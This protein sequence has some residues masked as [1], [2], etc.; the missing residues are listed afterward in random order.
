ML[1]LYAFQTDHSYCQHSSGNYARLDSVFAAVKDAGTYRLHIEY[2]CNIPINSAQ[3]ESEN[4]V[5]DVVPDRMQSAGSPYT[6]EAQSKQGEDDRD[7]DT[8]YLKRHMYRS[9]RIHLFEYGID[10]TQNSMHLMPVIV[11]RGIDRIQFGH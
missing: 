9:V 8:D 5:E 4:A 2:R 6:L 10:L 1:G 7:K 11:L 3:I